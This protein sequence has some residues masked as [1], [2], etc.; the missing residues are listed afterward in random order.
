MSGLGR[1]KSCS[2]QSN[3]A[4][5]SCLLCQKGRVREKG[6]SRGVSRREREQSEMGDWKG[7]RGLEQSLEGR[8]WKV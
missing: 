2:L 8:L 7:G 6:E 4:D 1:G 3:G 5:K